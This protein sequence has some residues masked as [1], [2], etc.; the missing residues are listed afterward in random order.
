M[1]ERCGGWRETG[2]ATG[3]QGRHS[4]GRTQLPCSKRAQGDRG[5][6]FRGV[7]VVLLQPAWTWLAA[8]RDRDLTGCGDGGEL[9]VAKATLA[10][11]MSAH[12]FHA[13][14][15]PLHSPFSLRI[16]LGAVLPILTMFHDLHVPWLGAGADAAR[17]LQRTLAFLDECTQLR[18]PCVH[19]RP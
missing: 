10:A 15:A 8:R 4:A 3:K 19:L 16:Y 12:L 6:W 13:R 17:E 5:G 18:R 14:L 7:V 1:G 9:V 2:A 11:V